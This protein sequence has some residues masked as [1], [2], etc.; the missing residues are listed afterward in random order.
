MKGDPTVAVFEVAAVEK[1]N[2]KVNVEPKRR[3]E[4]LHDG[5]RT[6]LTPL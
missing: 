2:V 6:G 3:S 5:D 1:E 4:P